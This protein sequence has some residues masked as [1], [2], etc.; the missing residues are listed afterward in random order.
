MRETVSDSGGRRKED[1]VRTGGKEDERLK[2]ASVLVLILRGELTGE[3]AGL[4]EAGLAGAL[5]S[6]S[7]R[8][9]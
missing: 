2:R 9:G 6:A 8:S 7:M 5:S 3:P 1:R 4:I